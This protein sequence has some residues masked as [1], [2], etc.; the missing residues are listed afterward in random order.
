[1]YKQAHANIRAD[2]IHKKKEAKEV[3][4]KR[5]VVFDLKCMCWLVSDGHIFATLECN[6]SI[7][8]DEFIHQDL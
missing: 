3:V 1:M 2:P 8:H 6:T 7:A 4:K 5:Y